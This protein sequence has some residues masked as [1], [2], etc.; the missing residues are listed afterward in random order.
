V[1]AATRKVEI[2]LIVLS[3]EVKV[4]ATGKVET[5]IIC[6]VIKMY[7]ISCRRAY[8]EDNL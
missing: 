3:L 6:L 8:S 4:S 5:M 1:V 2:M 7:G